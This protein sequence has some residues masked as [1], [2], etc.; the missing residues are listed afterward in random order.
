MK[1]VE[2]RGTLDSQQLATQGS[3]HV[4]PAAVHPS[5]SLHQSSVHLAGNG[6]SQQLGSSQQ[7]SSSDRSI[8][9]TDTLPAEHIAPSSGQKGLGPGGTHILSHGNLSVRY[10]RERDHEQPRTRPHS[11][12]HHTPSRGTGPP[13]RTP[14]TPPVIETLS[15]DVDELITT[16]A[17][18]SHPRTTS[19][20]P[21]GSQNQSRAH[22]REVT[23][24]AA[25]AVRVNGHRSANRSPTS[26]TQGSPSSSRTT[27]GVEPTSSPRSVNPPGP[28]KSKG[29][30]QNDAMDIDGDGDADA[31]ADIDAEAE[32]DA[33]AEAEADADAE[34]LEAVDAAE[35]NQ[36]DEEEEWLKKEEM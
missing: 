16:A 10:E 14:P 26:Q 32:L 7:S 35:A 33:D 23:S 29:A 8:H 28:V 17:Q 3:M 13:T 18:P 36:V 21:R 15:D 6:R 34:L 27:N 19:R 12:P 5:S 2:R 9:R 31:D 4:T 11:P 30:P 24:V 20:A 22:S 1:R 25:N